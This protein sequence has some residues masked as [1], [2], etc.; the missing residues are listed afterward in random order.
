[1]WPF[2]KSWKYS[3]VESEDCELADLK[4]NP[5]ETQQHRPSRYASGAT[6]TLLCL[7]LILQTLETLRPYFPRHSLAAPKC[8]D[9]VTRREW[10]SLSMAEKHDYL[11]AVQCL[12]HTPSKF[13]D[14]L[15][16]YDDF[17]HVH[18]TVGAI[19]EPS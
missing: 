16:R 14:T 4:S 5:V 18:D 3:E 9:P 8:K 7:V 2:K 6:I 17:P 1:M 15:T 12:A 13:N 19:C 10:R 11:N